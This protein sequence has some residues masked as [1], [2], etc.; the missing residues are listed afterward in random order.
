M[1]FTINLKENLIKDEIL[2]AGV[3]SGAALGASA[4]SATGCSDG[5]V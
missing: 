1:K 2:G 3:A 4:D 5:G